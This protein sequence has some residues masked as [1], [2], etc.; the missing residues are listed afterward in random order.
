MTDAKGPKCKACVDKDCTPAFES[1]SGLTV[2]NETP[3]FVDFLEAAATDAC[4]DAAD[5]KVWTTDGK[6]DFEGDLSACGHKCLGMSSCTSKCIASRR[7][8]TAT[9]ADCFGELTGCTKDHCMFD[10]M[11]DAQGTSCKDC[12]DDHCTPAFKTCSGLT[13]PSKAELMASAACA[14][15]ADQ[16][17]WTTDGKT[18][19]E[20]DLNACGHQCLG[21]ASCTSKCIAKRRGYTATCADCFGTLTGCTKD[22]CMFDCMTDAQGTSCKNCVDEHCTPAFETCSGLTPPSKAELRAP[23]TDACMDAAD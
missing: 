6:T 21:M 20:G 3:N 10:C 22:H 5:Q 11:T 13:P 23:Q 15:T 8:Y 12:V 14:D 18:D 16:K 2:P 1:C 7:G 9:C 4:K 19:F 17:V